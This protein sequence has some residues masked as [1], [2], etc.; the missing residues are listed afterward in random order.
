MSNLDFPFQE[1]QN[2]I[3]R[4]REK[5]NEKGLDALLVLGPENIH[6]VSGFDCAWTAPLGE[7]SGVVVPLDGEPRLIVRSLESKTVKKH[8]MRDSCM[9]ADWEGPWKMLKDILKK[10]KAARGTIGVEEN[11]ITVRQF[12]GLKEIVPEAKIVSAA[13][14]VESLMAQP[15][16]LE[17]EFTRKAGKIAQVGFEKAV[18]TIKEGNPYYEV[19]TKAT[20]AM[21]EA[22]MTEQLLFGKYILSCV[23]GGPDGGALHETDV[24]RKIQ[25]GDIVTPELW[26]TYKHYVSGA[27]GSVYV[28]TDPPS[29]V[30]DTYKVLSEMYLRTK[31]A[32][33]PGVSVG[34]VWQAGNKVYR[35]AYGVDYFRMLGLQQGVG[36]VGRLDRG[37]DILKPGM[38]YLV[39]PEV[40]DPLFICVCASLMITEEGCEEITKPLLE[41]V[42][43]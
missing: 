23:W 35:A 6:Y 22:G 26:G 21:Y 4:V 13:R 31:E 41:L 16:K 40:T 24:T 1:Y 14:L 20:E 10:C 15:S 5:M 33:K 18:E 43:V 7:F 9:Y 38:T 29:S 27:M 39:Q 3:T 17:I 36:F 32:M 42:T 28:G 34:E 11:L 30:T 8:W 25:K 12:N 37:Q 19:I 2:R